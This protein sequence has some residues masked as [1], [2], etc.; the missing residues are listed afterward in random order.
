MGQLPLVDVVVSG[1]GSLGPAEAGALAIL[2]RHVTIARI[3]GASAGAINAVAEAAGIEDVAALWEKFLTRGDL[4]D[5][6]FPGPL[7]P[8]GLLKSER[9][10]VMAG[11]KIRAALDAV[12]GTMRMGDLEKP[13]R[14]V[15]GN[16]STREVEVIDSANPAH[17]DL[18]VVDVLCATSAI[19]FV[20]DAQRIS[21]RS[22]TLYT[23]GG[24][25]ANCPAGLFDDAP[26]R[27]TVVVRFVEDKTPR[28]PKSMREFVGAVFDI[29]SDAANRAMP[30]A[31]TALEVIEIKGS[32]DALDFS[33]T[34]QEVR[35]R[36]TLGLVAATAWASTS[37]IRGAA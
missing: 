6:H 18:L 25:G 2:R 23:D 28:P 36:Y 30:S 19:P 31:K 35:R 16:L 24:T 26:E 1:A 12:F 15:V 34:P 17:A 13:C 10:G 27:P 8:L 22:S 20:I 37:R 5:F 33:L 29:R 11:K 4:E 21:Q 3:G 9:R 7:K 32:G 14:V